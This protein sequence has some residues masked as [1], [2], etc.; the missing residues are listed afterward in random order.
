MD[1]G[2]VRI[3]RSVVLSVI[4]AA[5]LGFAVLGYVTGDGNPSPAVVSGQEAGGGWVPGAASGERWGDLGSVRGALATITGTVSEVTYSPAGRNGVPVDIEG[6][7]VLL[8]GV[9]FGRDLER[10]AAYA[11]AV[12]R[13]RE[14]VADGTVAL[15][16]SGGEYRVGSALRVFVGQ[17]G[18]DGFSVLFA[19]EPDQGSAPGFDD[20][21]VAE[22]IDALT[23]RLPDLSIDE[24]VEEYARAS[25]RDARGQPV[26]AELRDLFAPAATAGEPEAVDGQ[27]P[28]VAEDLPADAQERWGSLVHVEVYVPPGYAGPSR[29]ALDVPGVGVA[30]WFVSVP[31][32]ATTLI[33]ELPTDATVRLIAADPDPE[34]PFTDRAANAVPISTAVPIGGDGEAV[35]FVLEDEGA[36]ATLQRVDEDTYL[37]L[38]ASQ[39]PLGTPSSANS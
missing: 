24:A 9:E 18:Q 7:R 38:I 26:R 39:S 1:G 34:D 23:R 22:G 30:G 31:E 19:L 8:T 35:Y 37:S 27:L 21:P 17:W 10:S 25:N 6:Q 13:L 5:A 12:A 28:V 3:G 29:L 33:G 32:T 15:H 20:G 11:P 16:F 14:D 2:A 36:D 4:G